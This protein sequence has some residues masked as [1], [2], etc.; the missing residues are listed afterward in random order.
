L[1]K[2]LELLNLQDFVRVAG[3]LNIFPEPLFDPANL[4]MQALF[5]LQ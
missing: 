1:M 4:C 3:D 2:A 5:Y